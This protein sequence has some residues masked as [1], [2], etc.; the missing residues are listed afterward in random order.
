MNLF[1]KPSLFWRN[2]GNKNHTKYISSPRKKIILYIIAFFLVAGAIGAILKLNA[3]FK[4]TVPVHG[5]T[6]S[7]GVV[8]VPRFINPVL[9]A[10]QTD[11]DLT[12]LVYSGLV[13]V[14]AS[15]KYA[16][17][18]A[19]DYSISSDGLTYT[20]TLKQNLK[21]QDGAPFTADDV[22]FTIG[23]IQDENINSPQS[24]NWKGVSVEKL[25][26]YKVA[27]HLKDP[28]GPFLQNLTIGILPKH[29]WENKSAQEFLFSTY[30]THPVGTGPYKM[31]NISFQ[32]SGVPNQYNLK[33]F[34]GY[35][36]GD[37]YIANVQLSFYTDTSNLEKALKN[38][39]IDSTAALD[40]KMSKGLSES[41]F[42]VET[43]PML[44]IFAT[45]FNQ[46]KNVIFA[47]K[48][49]REALALSV[50]KNQI[51]DKVLSGYGDTIN[52]PLPPGTIGYTQPNMSTSTHR[53]ALSQAKTLLEKNGWS[54]DS[55]Q[56]VYTKG[57]GA[58]KQ[59]LSF[60]LTTAQTP[61]L[62]AA[63]KILQQNWEN[64]GAKVNLK[65][66]QSGALNQQIIRPR[67]YQALLFGQITGHN[68]D[69]YAFWDSSQRLDPGLN[70]AMFTSTKADKLLESARA[71]SDLTQR[72]KKY[73]DFSGILQSEHPAVFLYTP[74]FTYIVPN[75]L[76]GIHLGAVSVSSERF[77]NISN[78]YLKTERVWKFFTS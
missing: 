58:K 65:F 66:A 17:D 60:T 6:L 4:I 47:D 78:W 62:T 74:D 48:S 2:K 21:W 27:F 22:I 16:P 64:L 38:G 26:T 68:P 31:G 28:Y 41:G 71:I 52:G 5:G 53:E 7:E 49:V 67:D 54:Y 36:L 46:N 32:S 59:I 51:V 34:S 56:K 40:A 13:K 44:R 42:R 9:A 14:D 11:R 70:V 63:A 19:K 57:S 39:D 15:G 3:S 76:K 20:V 37:P 29:L 1:S 35:A 24:P 23:K 77:S 25:S 61:E 55:K 30:N 10:T 73:Q 43:A 45:F 75:N 50:D 12:K 18:L 69:L 33:A 72:A 8:G